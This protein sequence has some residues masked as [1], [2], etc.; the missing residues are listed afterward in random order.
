MHETIESL[1]SL[2]SFLLLV[3]GFRLVL[4][5]IPHRILLSNIGWRRHCLHQVHVSLEG[6]GNLRDLF[7]GEWILILPQLTK[8]ALAR[9]SI[10]AHSLGYNL[11]LR[12]GRHGF[13]SV[14]CL[15]FLKFLGS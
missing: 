5:A 7:V 1:F 12:G 11:S 9:A 6:H 15:S 3:P 13:A 10:G 8:F 14:C 2:R 4:L